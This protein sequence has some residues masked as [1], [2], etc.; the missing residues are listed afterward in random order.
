MQKNLVQG[1]SISLPLS[2][3]AKQLGFR[4][5]LTTE[6]ISLP[7]DYGCLIVKRSQLKNKREELKKVLRATI[8]AYD[9]AMQEPELAK[10]F[11]GKY[12]RTTEPDVLDATH[13]E[14]LKE[15]ALRIP[16]VSLAG[17]N[18]IVDFRAET[19]PELRKF[20]LER[21]FDNSLLQEIQKE[22]A[23]TK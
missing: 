22:T 6:T 1:G 20:P 18:S 17:L 19:A 16:L 21:M 3:K 10:R 5:L 8:A 9:L 13:R 15:Y 12:T 2:L 4:E 14:N 23:L 11:I 7:F